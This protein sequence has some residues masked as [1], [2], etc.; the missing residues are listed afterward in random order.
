MINNFDKIIEACEYNK[1]QNY[2]TS[3][4][5]SYTQYHL[6]NALWLASI[7]YFVFPVTSISKTPYKGFHWTENSTN[8]KNVISDYWQK[9]P[10]GR[11]AID[12]R[13]SGIT[14]VDVDQK[15]EKGKYGLQ[16]LFNCLKK[17]GDLADN[18]PIVISPSGGLHL[19]FADSGENLL[20]D[21]AD[22]IDIRRPNYVLAPTSLNSEH[23]VYMPFNEFLPVSALPKLPNEWLK[24]LKNE[25]KTKSYKYSGSNI[26]YKKKV[27]DIDI[28][29][30]YEKCAFYRNCID[31]SESLKEILW[32]D[33]AKLLT[34]IK[35]GRELFHKYSENY[36]NYSFEEAENKFERAKQYPFSCKTVKTHFY[37][38]MECIRN[39][40]GKNNG[41]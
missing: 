11:I 22:C 17:W 5:L 3:N 13:K 28:A 25:T 15:P 1:K 2:Y 16:V 30:L 26:Q 35:N 8:N 33:F 7:G 34:G 24:Q 10:Y 27:L 38:C 40:K 32:F 29:P 36:P 9:Y 23:H 19:Y 20:Y 37:G 12:C 6:Q 21:Y 4:G 39:R 14:V 18:V 31:N 41:K